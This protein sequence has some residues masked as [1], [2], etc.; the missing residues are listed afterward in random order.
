MA[1]SPG[2]VTVLKDS[3][4]KAKR[5]LSDVRAALKARHDAGAS[6]HDICRTWTACV[7]EVVLELY[8][9]ALNDLEGPPS[10]TARSQIVLVGLGGFGRRDLAP[11]SDVDL[12]LLHRPAVLQEVAAVNRAL[13]TDLTDVGLVPALA[14][15]SAKEACQLAWRDVFVFSAEVEARYLGGSISLFRAFVEEF[16]RGTERRRAALITRLRK[17]RE[18]ERRQFGETVFLLEPNIKRSR[19]GLRDYHLLR[20]VGYAQFLQTHPAALEKQDAL[21]REDARAIRQGHEFLLRLRNELHFQE[22]RPQDVLRRSEQA[23]IGQQW[24]Y[25]GVAGQLP[26]EQFMR[27]YYAATHALHH[28][29]SHFAANT[30][31]PTLVQSVV[32]QF[33]TQRR[34]RYFLVNP[35]QISVT[36]QGLAELS[37]NLEGILRLMELAS[38]S[39]KRIAQSTWYA[40]RDDMTRRADIEV[41]PAAAQRFLSL[42]DHTNRLG[43]LLRML[44]E[45]RVLEKLVV[46]LDH[47]RHLVQFNEYHKYTVDEHCILAVEKA[48]EFQHGSGAL[49][50][51]YQNFPERAVLHLALLIHDVGKGFTEDHSDKGREFALQTA[52]R[53]N[54]EPSDTALLEFLVQNHLIMAHLAFRRDLSDPATIAHFAA[55]VGSLTNLKALFLLTA[56]DLAAVGPGVLNPWKLEVL[57]ELYFRTEMCLTGSHD[58]STERASELRE[59]LLPMWT[60]E[61]RDWFET[62]VRSL[63]DA[64]VLENQ[65]ADVMGDLQQLHHTIERP[66]VTWGRF[67]PERG[68]AVYSLGFRPGRARGTFHRIAAAFSSQGMNILAASVYTLANQSVL[69][70]IYAEDPDHPGEPPAPRFREVEQSLIEAIEAPTPQPPAFRARWQDVWRERRKQLEVLPTRVVIDPWT[71]PD[72]TI[73]DIFA[74]DRVGLLYTIARTLFDL[75]LLV[76]FAKISTNLDQ[77]VSVFYVTD[78]SR[79]KIVDDARWDQ[80]RSVLLQRIEQEWS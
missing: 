42:L 54:L 20:W 58:F 29:V 44:H 68:V 72:V 15:R 1:K 39:K 9:A 7:E 65:T 17:A 71:R 38:G 8:E 57:T 3:V 43:P 13:L 75:D 77:V 16:R 46:G 26:V 31:V 45:V 12:L 70:R 24:N 5:Q 64:Y 22:Q 34:D 49:S 18:E 37:G 55:D 80:I 36:R 73:I 40:I 79:R 78:S 74:H 59:E 2:G 66:A 10:Q 51:A 69:A 6:G 21:S 50:Y 33:S 28:A 19:G 35:Y 48:T 32:S 61:D 63:P 47:A 14:V 4:V 60:G 67:A 56:A 41:T 76:H 11:Y 53:L 27:D 52:A 25:P 23:R 30:Q 62:Q